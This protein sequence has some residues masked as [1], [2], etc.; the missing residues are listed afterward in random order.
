VATRPPSAA[1]T[2]AE[3][4]SLT[5]RIFRILDAVA[6]AGDP[7]AA[8]EIVRRT[9]L[10]KTTVH[11]IVND[12]VHV[13]TL[14][15]VGDALC[16]GAHV[17]ELGSVVPPNRRLREAALPFM[18][19]LYEATHE[20]IHLGILDG[21]DVLYLV[22]LSGHDRVPVPTRDG[23]RMPAHATGL[24][25]ALLATSPRAV[26][27]RVLTRPLPAMTPNTITGRADLL[28]ELAE[29]ARVGVAFDREEAF[30]G[31]V[32]VAAPITLPGFPSRAAVSVTGPRHRFDPDEAAHLVRLAGFSI[33]RQVE[34]AGS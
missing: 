28:Q 18:E 2:V 33:S 11:R 25:K 15:R 17:F 5:E 20:I 24:G 23:A 7:V 12:L 19:D 27:R 32:C 29:V 14:T 6:D 4:R 8:A 30:S 10:P 9:G 16:L 31:V 26:V 1:E 3:H 13:G 21:F 34:E 22:K